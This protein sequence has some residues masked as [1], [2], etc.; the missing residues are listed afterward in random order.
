MTF[1]CTKKIGVSKPIESPHLRK[2]DS[3]EKLWRLLLSDRQFY[4][5]EFSRDQ[6]VQGILIDFLCLEVK[7]G[8]RIESGNSDVEQQPLKPVIKN[9]LKTAGYEIIILSP[10]E[11]ND[12]FDQTISLLDQKFTSLTRFQ[13]G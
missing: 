6:I 5:F 2:E 10:E 12:S 4:A 8:I 9:T 7:F 1:L 13:C 11:V 3:K